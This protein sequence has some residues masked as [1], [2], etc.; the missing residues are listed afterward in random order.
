MHW[1]TKNQKRLDTKF[2]YQIVEFWETEADAD[3]G[4]DP[5]HTIDYNAGGFLVPWGFDTM[6]KNNVLKRT[7]FKLEGQEVWK[8]QPKTEAELADT[9]RFIQPGDV[10][11]HTLYDAVTSA[12]LKAVAFKFDIETYIKDHLATI[13]DPNIKR[14]VH[15]VWEKQPAFGTLPDEIKAFPTRGNR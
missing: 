6:R 10:I 8:L 1:R 15:P 14:E 4:D 11:E 7:E 9:D 3:R 13:R 5:I 2:V 12:A